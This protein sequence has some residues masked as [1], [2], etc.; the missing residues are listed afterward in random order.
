MPAA[1]NTGFDSSV[2]VLVLNEALGCIN[3]PEIPVALNT[4]LDSKVVVLVLNEALAA[5]NEPEISDD[6]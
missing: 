3:E 4:G 2:V 5:V 6:I 1:L